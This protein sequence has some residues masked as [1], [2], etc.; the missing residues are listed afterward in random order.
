MW[1]TVLFFALVTATEPQRMGIAAILVGLRRPMH[2]LF[3]FWVGLMTSSFA[4]AMLGMFVLR[5]FLIP[6]T[7]FLENA[8]KSPLVP[9]AQIALGVLAFSIA[10]AMVV[11]SAR[12]RPVPV[13]VPVPVLVPV[14]AS[15]GVGSD[16]SHLEDGPSDG[17]VAS[18][19]P[20]V[21]LKRPNVFLR[22]L[23]FGVGRTSWSTVLDSGSVKL[24]F[25]AGLG[26]STSPVE[27]W[28]A[29]LAIIASGATVGTQVSAV[30]M[31]ML[32]GFSIVEVPLV[33]FLVAPAK[34]QAVLL[35]VHRWLRAHHRQIFICILCVAGAM[36]ING[37]VSAA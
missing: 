17:E 24:S 29:V 21:A 16:P 32:V 37:G 3:A 18:Q 4:F 14:G 15:S 7:Q 13:P 20:E 26:T 1:G 36:M 25:A 27:F 2:N 12:R 10:A 30:L 31:F 33:C 34:T 23:A 11:R 6:F 28:G 5:D 22:A 9:P 8:A 19:R 35:R